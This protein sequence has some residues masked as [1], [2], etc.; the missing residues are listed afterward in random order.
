MCPPTAPPPPLAC[1]CWGPMPRLTS[2][3]KVLCAHHREA[4]LRPRCLLAHVGSRA[5][6]GTL[7]WTRAALARL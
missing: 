4:Q 3:L 6:E 2:W 5:P 7:H 1:W